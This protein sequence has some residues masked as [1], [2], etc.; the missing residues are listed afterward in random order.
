MKK[1]QALVTKASEPDQV[2]AYMRD[3]WIN[4]SGDWKLASDHC[5]HVE[6]T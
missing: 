5:S 6:G 4:Q 3:T 2:D 1:E